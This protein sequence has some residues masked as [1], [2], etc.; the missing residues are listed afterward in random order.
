MNR[1]RNP[2]QDIV[3]AIIVP[4]LFEEK[5]RDIVFG[6]PSFRPSVCPFVLPS[7]R[8]PIEYVPCVRNSSYSFTPI[9]LK[10]YRCF[11]HPLRKR[12]WFGYNPQNKIFTLFSQLELSHF[13]SI[14]TMKVNG[15]WVPCV[16]NSSYSFVLI[17]LKLYR[18]LYQ[19]LKICMWFGCDT[20]INFYYFCL[21]FELSHFSVILTN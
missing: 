19:A 3:C 17:L 12:M 2:V 18:C 21:Q 16:R 14:L 15:Q 7:F 9:L 10:L 11:Y 13:S 20:Q 8:P 5:R 6:F 4:R 1:K